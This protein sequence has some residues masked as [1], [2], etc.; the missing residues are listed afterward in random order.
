[1]KVFEVNTSELDHSF[2]VINAV[3]NKDN[4]NYI[5]PL[6]KEVLATFDPSKNKLFKDGAAK[7]W[8]I[9]DEAGKTLGRIA[10]FHY[11]KYKNKGTDFPTGCIGYFDAVDDQ[12]V[13][14]LLFDTAKAW[15]ISEGMEAMDGPVNFGDRD[16]WWGLMVE[17]YDR[18]PMYKKTTTIL[19]ITST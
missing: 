11:A 9:Q 4:P 7:R 18:E 19:C 17:G 5:R 14:N 12:M 15:L 2:L 8:I 3:V 10:A 6:D 1:M 16:K 13:A